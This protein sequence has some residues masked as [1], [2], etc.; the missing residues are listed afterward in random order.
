MTQSQSFIKHE[1]TLFNN[2]LHFLSIKSNVIVVVHKNDHFHEKAKWKNFTI[3]QM[4]EINTALNQILNTKCLIIFNIFR[5]AHVL[6]EKKV[7]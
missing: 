5:Q 7:S 1:L 6:S 2:L 4:K 3:C